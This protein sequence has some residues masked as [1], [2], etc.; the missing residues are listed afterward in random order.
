MRKKKPR[1]ILVVNPFGIGDV[2]FSTPLVRL[3]REHNPDGFIGYICNRRTESLLAT[4]PNIDEV[5]VYEKDEFKKLWSHSKIKCISSFI[6]QL[7]RIKKKRFNILIDLSLGHQYSLLALLFG[8]RQRIGFNYKNRGKFLTSK[9]DIDGY[10]SR[11]I[12]DYYLLL[13]T[14]LQIPVPGA[15]RLQFFV[16]PQDIQW[17]RTFLSNHQIDEQERIVGI[18]P[19]GGAS[20]GEKAAY[21]HWAEEKYIQLINRFAHEYSARVLIFG[22]ARETGKCDRIASQSTNAALNVCGRTNLG[23]FAALLRFCDIVIAND[24]GP[25]HVAVSQDA[26]TVSIFGPVDETVYG[27]YPLDGDHIVIKRQSDCRPCY[28]KFKIPECPKRICLENIEVADVFE[29]SQQLLARATSSIK[30]HRFKEKIPLSV[31]VVTKNEEANIASCLESVAWADEIIVVD[32]F[33]TDATCRIA[34]RYTDTI[35]K[36]K[37]EIEGL[38]RNWAYSQARNQW[39]LSLDAD[40]TVSHGLKTEIEKLLNRSVPYSAFSI[41]LRNYIGDYW[42]RHGGWY[43]AGKVRLFNKDK[44]KY[45]EVSVH[46][47]VFIDGECGHLKNDII[48]KGYPDFA[49][50]LSSLNR[51]TT[52]EAQKWIEDGRT[53]SFARAF[54]KHHDRFIKTYVLKRGYRDGFIGFMVAFFASLY[55]II[56]YAKYWELKKRKGAQE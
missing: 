31:V 46:P 2:L 15:A 33:S 19:G 21:K 26:P 14:F 47:R 1:N 50:F 23:E 4:N 49:H 18:I 44:F 22:D 38:H 12:V 41:P 27:P 43:P 11:H 28:N 7:F 8:I 16:Q 45:E 17:A 5:F 48:H 25:L 6:R 56:S 32:D 34:A 10:H 20:W 54:R 37:M 24:G 35:V 3:L 53:M 55:Q 30:A 39:V 29:A 40:E 9:I 51:Q 42:V 13:L 52:L 36:R